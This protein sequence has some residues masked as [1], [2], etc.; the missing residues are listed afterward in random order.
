MKFDKFFL[1]LS[2][3]RTHAHQYHL[4]VGKA[5]RPDITGSDAMRATFMSVASGF[6][7]V[8]AP[9]LI[10]PARAGFVL[11]PS[12]QFTDH[13]DLNGFATFQGT[14]LAVTS[15]GNTTTYSPDIYTF[16][17]GQQALV[18]QFDTISLNGMAGVNT[19]P[20]PPFLS[21]IVLLSYG[22]VTLTGGP[23]NTSSGFSGGLGAN[24]NPG[25]FSGAPGLGPGGGSGG[26]PVV[27]GMGGSG[28]GFGG[29]GGSGLPGSPLGGP[30]YPLVNSLLPGS[31]GGGGGEEFP[32]FHFSLGGRGG[33]GRGSIEISSLGNI[34]VNG[35]IFAN[36]LAGDPGDIGQGGGG[37]S[38]GAIVL[39]G[40]TVTLNG[41]LDVSGGDGGRGGARG[42]GGGAGGRVYIYT[43]PDGFINNGSINLAGGLGGSGSLSD[44]E[45]GDEGVLTVGVVPEPGSIVL[46]GIGA[47][48]LAGF[49]CGRGVGG[50]R[51]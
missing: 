24:A 43:N 37:G 18:Y 34:L 11:T 8:I 2:H 15:N 45:S 19:R 7:F 16:P 17:D 3:D 22:D 27:G 1:D 30:S 4:G 33:D 31:G 20:G 50:P 48:G 26:A 9:D 28:G 38:G 35:S 46:T 40:S 23:V 36:G 13:G 25:M 21:T 10:G 5:K 12:P 39:S 44:G 14:E 6:L 49:A 32:P 41:K 51:F 29:T 47:V 42:G